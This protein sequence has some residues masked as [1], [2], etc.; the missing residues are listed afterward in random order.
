MPP[1]NPLKILNLAPFAD[2]RRAELSLMQRLQGALQYGWQWFQN[3]PAQER[4]AEL[5]REHLDRHFILILNCPWP[6]RKTPLPPL[7]LGPSGIHLLYPTL[8]KGDF[9]IKGNRLWI[10]DTSKQRFRP[11]RPDPV[12]E[13]IDIRNMLSEFFSSLTATPMAI[14]AR[15]LFLDPAT[16]VDAVEAEI[17]PLM[18]DGLPR[19]LEQLSRQRR[20]QRSHIQRWLTALQGGAQGRIATPTPQPRPKKKSPTPRWLG[21]TRTQWIVLGV[22]ALLDLLVVVGLFIMLFMLD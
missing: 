12:Q 3:Y 4:L 21:M 20:Y 19:Y 1:I 17:A 22:L 5:L 9:R 11:Y 18:V 10:Y 6:D 15:I 7:L 2:R 8:L 14:E 13:V 16:Y